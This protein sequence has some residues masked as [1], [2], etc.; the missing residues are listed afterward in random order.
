[1]FINN[2]EIQN[3]KSLEEIKIKPTQITVLIGPNSSGKSSVLHFL[4]LLKQS[5]GSS[6]T[7][8][9]SP[10]G[11]IIKLG[12]FQD[13][14]TDHDESKEI[15][16][17]M[18]GVTWPDKEFVNTFGEGKSKF[19]YG[20]DIA[21]N[22]IGGVTFKVV[23]NKL[24]ISYETRY[25]ETIRASIY[26]K[27]GPTKAQA[28]DYNSICPKIHLSEYPPRS[29]MEHKVFQRYFKEPKFLRQIFD[30]FHLYLMLYQKS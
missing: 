22:R 17:L 23:H 11:N 16:F 24:I 8:V 18:E 14:V 13:V 7:G 5:I 21:H 6:G 12:N 19:E 26:F 2:I 27:E 1:M 28:T 29:E 3:F 4:A 20:V 30:K 25:E 9:F 10:D 15:S